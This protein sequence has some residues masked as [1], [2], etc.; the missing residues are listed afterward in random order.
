MKA[1]KVGLVALM[2]LTTV[3]CASRASSVAPV[4]IS[5]AEYSYLGCQDARAFL[6]TARA[7]ENALTRRQNNAATADAAAVFLF[8][9]PLGSVF[10]ADVEGELAQAK[11]ESLALQRRVALACTAEANA[12]TG[13]QAAT[14]AVTPVAAQG[15]AAPASRNCGVR[16]VG[17]PDALTC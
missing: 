6:A 16:V 12:V 8:A 7:K 11:G 5:A 10:G 15:A 9:L 17:N 14:S 4:A 13:T 3:S 1:V 2:A